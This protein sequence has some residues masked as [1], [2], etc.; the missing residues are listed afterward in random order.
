MKITLFLGTAAVIATS[1]AEPPI[2]PG[3]AIKPG[4]TWI[5]DQTE[6]R[7]TN[8]FGEQRI[9]LTVE[10]TDA[11]TML[12]GIK[13]DGAPTAYE[14]HVVGLDWSQRHIVDGQETPTTR[15]LSFPMKVGQN[16]TVSF[17]DATRRGMQTSLHV[18]RTY[19]VTGWEDVT[20]P[21]G[22]FHAIKIEATG[23]SDAVFVIPNA[24][25]GGAAASPLGGSTFT[26]SQRGGTTSKSVR[27]HDVFY[28]VPAINNW[29]KSVEEQF[30]SDDVLAKR[31]TR[32]MVAY[33]PAA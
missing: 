31:E 3:P 16:W 15:P 7:G 27:D 25:V 13:R 23:V 20:V 14:D 28:Y 26:R 18:Q 21:A 1:N 12:V 32:V 2:V 19:R 10:R 22:T 6:Q 33:H 11:T 17:S 5:F 9:A 30:N 8:G 24:V 4:D 29:V